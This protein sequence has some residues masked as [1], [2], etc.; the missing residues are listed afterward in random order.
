MHDEIAEEIYRTDIF[1]LAYRK[2]LINN[3]RVITNLIPNQIEISEDDIKMLVESASIFSLCKTDYYKELAYKIVTSILNITK[4]EFR[5]NT[6]IVALILGRLSNFPGIRLLMNRLLLEEN[7]KTKLGTRFFWEISKKEMQNSFSI[8]ENNEVLLTDF[9]LNLVN[10]LKEKKIVSF[11]APTSAGKSYALQKYIVHQLL[12]NELRTVIYIVPTRALINQ[13]INDLLSEQ[14]GKESTFDVVSVPEPYSIIGDNKPIVYVLT[15]ERAQMLLLHDDYDLEV[16]LV[17]V[18]EAQKIADGNRGMVLQSVIEAL[19]NRHQ[20]V[21]VVFSSPLTENPEVL[22]KTFEVYDPEGIMN[23]DSSPV[24]QNIILLDRDAESSKLRI[25]LLLDDELVEV[26]TLEKLNLPSDK[27]GI[28]SFIANLIGNDTSSIIYANGAAEAEK[29]AVNLIN[30][31]KEKLEN[32]VEIDDFVE[33]LKTNVHKEFPLVE[34]L[35]YGIAFHYGNMPS[36]IRHKIEDLFKRGII[37]FLICTSTLLEGMNLPA[38]NIFINTPN[39]GKDKPMGGIDFWNL[40]GRAGRLTK[41]FQGNIYCIDVNSWNINP[42][43]EGKKEKITPAFEFQLKTRPRDLLSFSSDPEHASGKDLEIEYCYTKL[44]IKKV[45]E[46]F[47][48]TN[49]EY[50]DQDLMIYY[51]FIKYELDQLEEKLELPV[52]IIEKNPSISPLRQQEM[53]EY[54]KSKKEDE[55]VSL[56][57][58][59]PQRKG[60]YQSFLRLLARIHRY[61][62]KSPGQH[63]RYFAKIGMPW[64]WG[65][66]ISDILEESIKYNKQ[67]KNKINVPS[68]IRGILDN[69]EEDLRFRYV[70]YSVCYNDLLVF[71]LKER[72]MEELTKSIPN[73]PLFLEFG[74]SSDTMLNFMS[75][76]LSRSTSGYLAKYCIN[77]DLNRNQC[78]EWLKM[79]NFELFDIPS[80]CL[81]EVRIFVK[82]NL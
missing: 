52:E 78:K 39:R 54:F 70:K 23:E 65:M 75:L 19:I 4:D 68:L 42:L 59:H 69:I 67:K 38:K 26:A 41:D 1:R 44:F 21:K 11:S 30:L 81:E 32:S 40:A 5:I 31:R 63:N 9:Q 17:V 55:I 12:R 13:V 36:I 57:P 37:K 6:K 60:A 58:L 33:F 61:F 16:D 2:L 3:A 48:I 7:F 50:L 10:L 64:M 34:C 51:V 28:L 8:E 79:T 15:Q 71:F 49:I 62:E 77:K 76:G 29:I 74:A 24:T 80:V 46:N 56:I 27:I 22:P 43:K 20:N 82:L 73:I 45:K 72:G 35:P 18:D 47:D 25:S 53:Y 66:P 14:T